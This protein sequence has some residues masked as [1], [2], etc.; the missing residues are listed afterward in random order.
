VQPTIL[1]ID[2]DLDTAAL[3]RDALRERGFHV[4]AV[5]SAAAGLA[6]LRQVEFDVVVTDVQMA[7]MSGIELCERLRAS[8]PDLITIVVTGE[9]GVDTAIAAIRAGAYDYVT[10]PVK[11]DV[12][13]IAV[14]RALGHSGMKRELR[15]LRDAHA[16]SLPT[17]ITGASPAI[18]ETIQMVARVAES[19]VTVLITG[20]SGTGKELVAR[21][22]H[23]QSTRRGEPFIA[24]N[25]AAMPAPLLESELFGHVRGAFTDALSSRQ[26]LFARAKGGTIFLDEIGEM[27]LEM[28]V[29]LLRVL[30]QRTVRPVGGDDEVPIEARVVTATNR[31]LEHEVEAKRF[32]MDLYYRINVV[33]I[34]VPPLRERANDILT[35]AQVF[36]QRVAKRTKKAVRSISP[37][38]ARRLLDYDWP[39]N[40]RELENCMERAVALCHLDEV[41]ISDLPL[42]VLAG[43]QPEV[44][45][46]LLAPT[47]MVTIDELGLRY[48]RKV[49]ALTNGN[50]SLAARVLGIDRREIYRRLSLTNEAGDGALPEPPGSP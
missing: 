40:V 18:L 14:A 50:K 19:D 47:E 6:V 34:N 5:H 44:L 42:A 25:C 49:L 33:Q 36:L 11:V 16:T 22:L 1:V 23:D 41:T 32:R 17:G 45:I 15:R 7:E 2:D 8:H 43:E 28:Q 38:A 12:L 10:K 48:V 29:K 46:S 20:E 37:S 4:Q 9:S 31:N 21:A 27:P 39:G 35:L 26:G 30:Q 13:A 24:I 3:M